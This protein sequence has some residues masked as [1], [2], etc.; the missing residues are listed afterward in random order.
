[1]EER[2][3]GTSLIDCLKK[4]SRFEWEINRQI[5]ALTPSYSNIGSR[6]STAISY[7][8]TTRESL[9]AIYISQL[10]KFSLCFQFPMRTNFLDWVH[11]F[12]IRLHSSSPWNRLAYPLIIHTFLKNSGALRSLTVQNISQ[13]TLIK[14][15][16]LC[17]LIQVES[18]IL[19]C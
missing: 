1:M 18:I 12:Y 13:L 11:D 19:W 10:M 15:H 6:A 7:Q 17:D 5:R 2:N 14:P 9:I 4:A 8:K 16:F 3:D